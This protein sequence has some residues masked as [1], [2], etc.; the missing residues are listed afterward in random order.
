MYEQKT[1]G[2]LQLYLKVL[3]F[4]NVSHRLVQSK[5]APSPPTPNSPMK[6][7]QKWA[8]QPEWYALPWGWKRLRILLNMWRGH[9]GDL[10]TVLLFLEIKNLFQILINQLKE[11][12]IYF[13]KSAKSEAFIDRYKF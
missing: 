3:Q 5:S 2:S 12:F 7:V 1:G 13:S 8:S 10:L 6:S 9:W 11:F 4:N